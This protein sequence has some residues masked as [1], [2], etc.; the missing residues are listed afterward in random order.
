MLYPDHKHTHSI[1]MCSH[2]VHTETDSY[3]TLEDLCFLFVF[4]CSFGCQSHSLMP[5]WFC[6]SSLFVF[7][8]QYVC[9]TSY[10]TMTVYMK[11]INAFKSKK[12]MIFFASAHKLCYTVQMFGLR[13]TNKKKKTREQGQTTQIMC[14]LQMR[15]W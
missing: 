3:K 14:L 2:P 11:K 1:W 12:D 5:L 8:L 9:H 10:D 13:K 4:G 15:R 6:N 7:G